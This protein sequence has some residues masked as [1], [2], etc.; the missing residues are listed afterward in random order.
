MPEKHLRS[1]SALPPLKAGVIRHYSMLYCP[2]AQRVRLVLAHK[3]I[4]HETVNVH[5]KDKPEWLQQKN[6]QGTVPILELDDKIIYESTSVSEYLDDVFPSNKLQPSD[7]YRKAQDRILLEYLGKLGA[8]FYTLLLKP[9]EIEKVAEDLGKHFKYYEDTL[10]KRGGPYFGGKTPA[11][12]DFYMWPLFERFQAYG[13]RNKKIYID[14]SNYPK[15]AEWLEALKTLPAVQAT[16]TDTK[17]L[18]H[19]LDSVAD[20]T[21]DYDYGIN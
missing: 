10:V 12:I 9:E 18:L 17:T 11:M 7:P 5:L 3:N 19:F 2:F 6:P 15:L 14:K 16:S 21:F 13:T 1:G 4:P 20:G 8:S